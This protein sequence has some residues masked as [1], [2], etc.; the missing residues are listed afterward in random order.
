MRRLEETGPDKLEIDLKKELKR[1][2]IVMNVFQ[3]F[4]MMMGLPWKEIT[5][6]NLDKKMNILDKLT[7]QDMKKF[8]VDLRPELLDDEVVTSDIGK[9]NKQSKMKIRIGRKNEKDKD[10]KYNKLMKQSAVVI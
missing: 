4:L 7:K 6:E 3:S 5:L 2:V 9:K 1:W 10:D 8:M